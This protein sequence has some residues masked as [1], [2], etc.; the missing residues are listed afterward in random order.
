MAKRK[1]EEELRSKY[2]Q[3]VEGSLTYDEIYN[4]QRVRIP[5]ERCEDE[6]NVFTSDLHQTKYCRTCRKEVQKEKRRKG[7]GKLVITTTELNE[8][9][10]AALI[11]AG[12][13]LP[14]PAP[15]AEVA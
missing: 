12:V 8:E 11:A 15:E 13:K 6:F 4:K 1:T 5:C 9:Q 2:P 14:E 7:T 3:I 10:R